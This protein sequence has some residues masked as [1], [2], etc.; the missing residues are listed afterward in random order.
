MCGAKTRGSWA[1]CIL[2]AIEL[3]KRAAAANGRLASRAHAIP[4]I[5]MSVNSKKRVVAVSACAAP[6]LRDHVWAGFSMSLSSK[7]RAAARAKA[8]IVRVV[9]RVVD[10]VLAGFSMRLSSNSELQLQ[11]AAW[12]V[13][14][15]R[16]L[17]AQCL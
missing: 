8:V 3:K 2:N 6:R 14:R 5:S 4:G 11:T 15:M 7:K 12:S 1:G 16:Y 13:E 10:H 9:P 17:E